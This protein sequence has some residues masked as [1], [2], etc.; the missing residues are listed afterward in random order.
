[1]KSRI[2]YLTDEYRTLIVNTHQASH[3]TNHDYIVEIDGQ[4]GRVKQHIVF[5]EQTCM[6][7][8][9]IEHCD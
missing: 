3:A 2:R 5:L 4:S 6:H 9:S 8:V 7:G 1:M